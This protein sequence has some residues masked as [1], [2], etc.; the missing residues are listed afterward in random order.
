MGLAQTLILL[1]PLAF[2]PFVG[3]GFLNQVDWPTLWIINIKY[4]Y[5][6]INNCLESYIMCIYNMCSTCHV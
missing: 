4:N 2:Q 1:F 3:F 5:T 6:K